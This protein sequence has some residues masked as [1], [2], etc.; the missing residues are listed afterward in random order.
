MVL[1]HKLINGGTDSTVQVGTLVRAN[2]G[3]TYRMPMP[4][5]TCI[6]FPKGST[7]LGLVS[8]STAEK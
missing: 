6:L 4:L 3:L 5:P 8:W 7:N 2:E 1:S